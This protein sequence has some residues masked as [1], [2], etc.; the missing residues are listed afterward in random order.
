MRSDVERWVVLELTRAGEVRA[1]D[2]TLDPYLRG[3]LEL[4]PSHPVVIPYAKFSRGPRAV[5]IKVLEG[6]AFVATG[7]PEVRYFSL[8]GDSCIAGVLCS[9]GRHSMKVL[10]VVDDCQIQSLREKLKSQISYN[11]DVDMEV[12]VVGGTFTGLSGRVVAVFPDHVQVYFEFKS[13]CVMAKIEKA[14]IGI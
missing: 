9:R 10:Q 6:Y 11:I 13:R 8:E 2:G 14:L 3:K 5:I 12:N 4:P 1:I 7:L